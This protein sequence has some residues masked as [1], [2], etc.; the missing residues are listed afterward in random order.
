MVGFSYHK[1][2]A[3]VLTM[4]TTMETW[5]LRLRRKVHKIALDPR[6]Q[7]GAKAVSY[8]GSGFFLSAAALSGSFQPLAM[9]FVCAVT[10][11][12]AV[13]AAAGAMAGYRIFWGSQGLQGM[14]WSGAGCLLALFLGKGKL[15]EEYPLL[16]PA[17]TGVVTAVTGLIF[18]FFRQGAVFPL[19][20]LR[21]CLAPVTTWF[22]RRAFTARDTV[23]RW[24]CGGIAA[25]ALA[26]VGPLGYGTAGVWAVWASFPAAAMAGLG[27]DLARVT[28][29]PMS[30]VI[31]A[32]WL[33]RMIPFRERWIRFGMPAV[34][35]LAV[36]GLCGIWDLRP[37]PGL[38]LGGI[39]GYFLPPR[40]DSIHRQG[41][42][43]IAQV[44]LELTAGVLAQTQ[45]LLLEVPIPSIDEGALL[46][47]A[48]NRACG[49]CP[50]K[51]SCVERQYLN[52][53]HL[54][55]PLTFA[56]R[57]PWEIQGELLRAQERLRDLKAD[58]QRQREYRSAMVQQY[59][60]LSVYLQ[61]LSDQLP[62][63][64][65]RLRAYYHLE[66]SARSRG[67]ERANGDRCLA[68]PGAGCRYYVLLCDGMGTGLGAAQAGQSTGALLRQMLTAGFPPEHAFR[69]LNS[70]LALR[71][72]AGAVTLDL[73]EIRLDSGRVSLYK[74][75]AAP[76]WLWREKGAEK[77]GTATPPP[78]I[79]VEET[80]ESVDRLSLRRGEVLILVS[81]GAEIGEILR[82]EAYRPLP[83][84]ELAEW[85]LRECK[86]AG[87]DDATVAVL[88]LSRRQLST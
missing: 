82:R 64:G 9:A 33:G 28:A 22:F 70:I 84:G 44:R 58:R 31:C 75:G 14:I 1:G 29:V 52:L 27:L 77:I 85:L 54:H 10:G 35:C 74:W 56:C 5:V 48:I 66:L 80:K 20:L 23:T 16:I 39:L 73:A 83:P 3:V 88:R 50:S 32:A 41:E 71:G 25:L 7:S 43:G 62:R 45:R 81:D 11:W 24:I 40:A 51:E 53:E 42:T 8:G 55:S 30:V 65:E 68:F 57:R 34:A 21:V 72:Q 18:L 47:R 59:Q 6:V 2:K 26:R 69:S 12:R 46:N 79:S 17:L 63:R 87:E 86:A 67:K 37:L 49:N 76:S 13:L 15:S 4:I 36:L 19:F 78:G 38:I 60:F 61:R